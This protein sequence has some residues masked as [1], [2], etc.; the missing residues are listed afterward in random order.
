VPL[1]NEQGAVSGYLKIVRDRT[2]QRQAQEALAHAQE[3]LKQH[4]RMLEQTVEQ[5]TAQLRETV[6]ELESFS[7]SIS[8]DMRAPLR[9]MQGFAHILGEDFNDKLGPE[10]KVFVDKISTAATRLDRLIGDILDYS[11]IVRGQLPLAPV[12]VEKLVREIIESYPHL[13]PPA[14]EISVEGTFPLVIGN[15]AALTQCISNLLGNAVKFVAPGVV[16]RVQIRAERLNGD[17]RLWFEDN[18]I[19]MSPETQKK[20]FTMFHRAS[21]Q[22]EGTGIGLAIVRRAVERMGGRAG[23]ESELGKGSRFWL[24]LKA[25]DL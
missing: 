22:Y 3:E 18:G 12:N 13:Q 15:E 8:H 25:A 16:P 23:V 4:A 11:R 7:Y 1:R 24:Q 14:V 2:E 21:A 10:G 5:R 20:L 19:G 6:T 9:A 17:V